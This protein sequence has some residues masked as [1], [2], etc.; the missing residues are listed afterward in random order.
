MI[1]GVQ[2]KIEHDT[3]KKSIL[4]Y[5]SL[6]IDKE[7]RKVTR[8]LFMDGHHARAVEEG[9]KCLNNIIKRIAKTFLDGSTMMK[10]VFSVKSP[11]IRLNSGTSQ[12]DM[13]E[14][15]GYMEIY[16]GCMTGIRNPRAHEHEW[17]DTEDRALQ[18]LSLANHLIERAKNSRSV[19]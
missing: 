9:F 7:L 8:K 14:Q 6:V 15:L 3:D 13:D 17:E 11:I 1:S 10:S 16:S 5:D 2:S 18:L 19:K 12:S 4:L